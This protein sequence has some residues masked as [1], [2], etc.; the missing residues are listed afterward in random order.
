MLDNHFVV[1]Q[2]FVLFC[3]IFLHFYIK[4]LKI[5]VKNKENENF[6]QHL[7]CA[8]LKPWSNYTTSSPYALGKDNGK[9]PSSPLH[10][11]IYVTDESCNFGIEDCLTLNCTLKYCL[12]SHEMKHALRV[13]NCL[14]FDVELI[15]K[16][17]TK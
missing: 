7:E 15:F 13:K 9:P 16:L 1:S 17:M 2:H 4:I 12:L 10:Y 14:Y 11:I 8:S 6:D 3:L 5:K